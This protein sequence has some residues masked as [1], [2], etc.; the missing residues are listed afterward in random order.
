MG[1]YGGRVGGRFLRLIGWENASLTRSV[2]AVADAAALE[3]DQQAAQPAHP[4]L[5]APCQVHGLGVG[6]RGR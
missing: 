5:P 6:P 2:R 4:V 1:W 3:D